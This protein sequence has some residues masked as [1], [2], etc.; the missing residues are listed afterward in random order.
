MSVPLPSS[1]RQRTARSRT[2]LASAPPS[3][4][5]LSLPPSSRTAACHAYAVPRSVVSAPYTRPSARTSSNTSTTTIQPSV[6][7]SRRPAPRRFPGGCGA[8]GCPAAPGGSLP[9]G[10]AG[11]WAET[12]VVM[13]GSGKRRFPSEGDPKRQIRPHASVADA[14]GHVDVDGTD[15]AAPARADAH[16]RIKHSFPPGVGRGADVEERGR[17]PVVRE[18]VLIFRRPRQQILGRQHGT[19][20][21]V[22][23]ALVTIA[24]H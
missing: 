24:T 13:R 16:A 14:V 7:S 18:P 4:V 12:S 22:T 6:F 10:G 17:A 20:N 8:P 19:L 23:D 21:V 2:P 9:G 5:P 15:R 3:S 1:A 11:G